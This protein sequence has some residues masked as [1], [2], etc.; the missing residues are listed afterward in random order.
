MDIPYFLMQRDTWKWNMN[1]QYFRKM[2]LLVQPPLNMLVLGMV[3]VR[4]R[5]W[6]PLGG[7][8]IT[9]GLGIL[10][11]HGLGIFITHGLGIFDGSVSPLCCLYRGSC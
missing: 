10:I 3:Q 8:I 9:H 5:L 1:V 2:I 11:T 6:A 4:V 7:C